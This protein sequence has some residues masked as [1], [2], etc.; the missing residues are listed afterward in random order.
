MV[1]LAC[2]GAACSFA[3]SVP[4]QADAGRVDG[5]AQPA[6]DGGTA[7]DGGLAATDACRVL[8]LSRCEYLSRCGLIE[9]SAVGLEACTRAAEATWC[10]PM[11]WPSHVAAGALRYDPV[12]AQSCAQAFTTQVCAEWVTLPDSCTNFLKPRVQL[13]Q[14]CYDGYLECAD[15]VCRGNSCPRTCQPRALLDEACVSDGDC[16]TGLYCRFATF[17]SSVGTCAAF[18][19]PGGSCDT[20]IKCLDGLRCVNQQC[21]ALPIVGQACLDGFCSDQAYCDAQA[22]DGGLCL[23]R[24][25]TAAACD[26]NQCLSTLVCDPTSQSCQPVKLSSGEPCTPLQ[27]CPGGQV[28][29]ASDRTGAGTCSPPHADG[30]PCLGA[31][32]CQRHLSCRG[33]DG[34]TTCQPRAT[35]GAA[36]VTSLD[37]LTSAVCHQG[38]CVELPLPG[39]SCAETRVCRWGL[40]REVTNT[41]GGAICGALLSAGQTCVRGE[42]CA[43]GACDKGTCLARCVP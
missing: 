36:C 13:G 20:N 37:C 38:A 15:G 41:D 11:T 10:G 4:A 14:P 1:A 27:Q 28:C 32:D 7:L 25:T 17:M 23:T 43:S 31:A 35:M 9:P 30:E 33:G 8:N 18:N 34:G 22:T 2:L 39:E 29:V 40:C 24:K 3:P 42:Q 21:R 5:G 19:G 6:D 16:R 26:G 12:K